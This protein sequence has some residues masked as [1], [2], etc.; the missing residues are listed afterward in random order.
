MATE[1]AMASQYQV[2]EELGSKYPI[3][4]L[5]LLEECFFFFLP[6]LVGLVLICD[7]CLGGSFG[8]VY[9]AIERETGDIVAIKHVCLQFL[10]LGKAVVYN[11]HILIPAQIDLE[12][13]EDD[14]QEIQQEIA[15][16][17]TCASPFVTQYKTSF[18]RGYKLWIVMEYLGG[19]S[20]L[21][22]VWGLA[23]CEIAAL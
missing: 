23:S 13:S 5:L 17:S 22:L 19:G 20:C 11:V 12:S 15:V 2:L 6:L 9:K 7:A 3:S 16:L 8:V 18:V 14:I 4:P 1:A 10:C 21:D